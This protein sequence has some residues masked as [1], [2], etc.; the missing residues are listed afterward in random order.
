[1]ESDLTI[2]NLVTRGGFECEKASS[3]GLMGTYYFLGI[4]LSF[5]IWIKSSDTWGRKPIVLLGSILQLCGYAGILFFP[6]TLT[7]QYLFFFA[8][9]LGTVV[10]ISTSYNYLNE[11][12]PNHAKIAFSTLFLAFQILPSLVMPVFLGIIDEDV[13]PVLLIGFGCSIA[14]LVLTS[15]SIPES[16]Q[17]LFAMEKFLEC[18]ES[19][20]AISR[21]NG[22]GHIVDMA[23]LH[24]QKIQKEIEIQV[25]QRGEQF[26]WFIEQMMR[27][28]HNKH[29]LIFTLTWT[30]V[31]VC[32]H[33]L[34]FHVTKLQ[35]GMYLNG[36]MLALAEFAANIMIGTFLTSMG[37]KNT[38]L[39]SFT[40][41]SLASVIYLFPI[42][43]LD[44]WYALILFVLKFALSS[45]FAATFFGT[46]ALFRGDL[47]AI[48]FALCN[49]F[50]RLVTMAAPVIGITY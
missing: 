41:A 28:N 7:L 38:L 30:V 33:V 25:T 46:N 16:P 17:Y 49:M 15:L 14:G 37:V 9:G 13:Y 34:L 1:M 39:A 42:I 6:F 24:Q 22:A 36:F 11:F 2:E 50:A 3:L 44:L 26:K 18:Q 47:V 20:N 45:A 43:P 8:L 19:L 4:V 32:Y 23:V 12:L 40:L 48:I 35:G 29:M 27:N 21:F 5:L 31:S 10:S